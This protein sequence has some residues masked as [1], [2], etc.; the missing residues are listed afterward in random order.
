M[1]RHRVF[2]LLRLR[3]IGLSVLALILALVLAACNS[4]PTTGLSGLPSGL[5]GS[6]KV[7]M[8]SFAQTVTST[9]TLSGL[10]PG[11]YTVT[12][13]SVTLRRN[14]FDGTANNGTVTVS[15]GGTASV[16]VTY[17]V[18]RGDLWV[19]DQG[20]NAIGHVSEISSA[21]SPRPRGTNHVARVPSTMIIFHCASRAADVLALVKSK[22]K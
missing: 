6:V 18:Q 3:G 2:R 4:A 5:T 16:S 12:P 15:A 22:G 8:G 10:V 14:A 1:R 20:G 11:T 9:T 19:A 7:T 13:Q 17:A 21:G